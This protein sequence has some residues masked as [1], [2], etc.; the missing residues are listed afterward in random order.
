[1]LMELR[2]Q[3]WSPLLRDH[4]FFA[5]LHNSHQRSAVNVCHRAIHEVMAFK[6]DAVFVAGDACAQAVFPLTGIHTYVQ[7]KEPVELQVGHRS[8]L[9]EAALWVDIWHYRG[10]L[11][12]IMTGTIAVVQADELMEVIKE[13][14]LALF[15][16]GAY[17]KDFVGKLNSQK[18][19]WSDLPS[20]V[21]TLSILFSKR[22][23]PAMIRLSKSST[24]SRHS[25]TKSAR[26]FSAKYCRGDSCGA[27]VVPGQPQVGP[28]S[29]AADSL[30]KLTC[31]FIV[32]CSPGLPGASMEKKNMVLQPQGRCL[33]E[34]S[35]NFRR[36]Q[37]DTRVSTNDDA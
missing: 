6:D 9:C 35:G 18:G 37:L 32:F 15:D 27:P 2:F 24:R 29:K 12:T 13:N 14:A 25:N 19:A 8:C 20:G 11:W 21:S 4:S 31:F 16:T 34:V 23:A 1:M 3:T 26:T 33:Y 17:A 5:M 10:D 28:V 22:M 7:D 30:K 36:L